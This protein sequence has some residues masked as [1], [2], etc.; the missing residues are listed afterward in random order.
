MVAEVIGLD[1]DFL[2]EH[3]RFYEHPLSRGAWVAPSGQRPT[4]AQVMIS[5]FVGSS[6][7]SGSVRTARSLEPASDSVSPFLSQPLPCSCSVF[8]KKN[9]TKQNTKKLKIN[10]IK[11]EVSE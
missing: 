7:A 4:S 2:E 8:L 1:Q 11:R 6:P 3:L 10:P 9:E 5:R